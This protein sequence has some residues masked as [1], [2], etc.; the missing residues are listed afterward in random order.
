MKNKGLFA[1]I[2]DDYIK[3]PAVQF[4]AVICLLFVLVSPVQGGGGA[5]DS[6]ACFSSSTNTGSGLTK[7]HIVKKGETLYSISRRYN[8][9]I[10]DII[11]ENPGRYNNIRAGSPLRIPSGTRETVRTSIKGAI[12]RKDGKNPCFSWPVSSIRDCSR[13]GSEGVRSIG[14]VI[15][16]AQ[17]SMV[18]SSA[19]GVVEKVGQ[20][21]GFGRYVVVR[22]AGRY[23]T[24]YSLLGHVHV[25]EGDVIK[26]GATIGRVMDNR[27]HFQIDRAGRPLNPLDILPRRG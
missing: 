27:L 1:L 7:L 15:T 13:D 2:M 14:I 26:S 21:R 4:C 16:G 25:S 22:H 12:S 23:A 9:D 10:D 11:K 6:R 18:K 3:K 20:M 17:G 24:V 19:P 8:V 5:R